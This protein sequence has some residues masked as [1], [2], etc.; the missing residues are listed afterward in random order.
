MISRELRVYETVC[1]IAL[2]RELVDGMSSWWAA[3]HG[4][5]VPSLDRAAIA[6]IDKMSHVMFGG[7]TH[8]AAIKLGRQLVEITPEPLEKV[9]LCDSGSVSGQH[10]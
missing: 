3:I 8:E 2:F 7:L 6:Q 10:H 9:F 5:G 1:G 4:Y